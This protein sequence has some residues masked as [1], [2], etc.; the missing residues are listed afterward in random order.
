MILYPLDRSDHVVI[1]IAERRRA[2]ENPNIRHGAQPGRNR[3]HPIHGRRAVDSSFF[4]AQPATKMGRL[5][6]Y[7]YPFADFRCGHSRGQS[8]G[9]ASDDQHVAMRATTF[10]A[11][12]V[13]LA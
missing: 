13:R 1:V 12:W 9:S 11:V 6:Q 7:N 2:G 4:P 5:F 8:S 10:I 3:V